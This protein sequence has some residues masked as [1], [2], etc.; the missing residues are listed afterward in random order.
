MLWLGEAIDYIKNLAQ[1]AL[2]PRPIN[3]VGA[4]HTTY[5]AIPSHYDEKGQGS[6]SEISEDP[7]P[8][9]H[10]AFTLGSFAKI[11]QR[12]IEEPKDSSIWVGPDR[13][14]CVIDDNADD[15]TYRENTI[16]L[17][18]T[19]S[20]MFAALHA[21]RGTKFGQKEFLKWLNHDATTSA[22]DPENLDMIIR[23]IKF[24][25]S[26]ETQL[27][28]E[29]NSVDKMGKSV[30]AEASSPHGTI[31]DR[32]R[33]SFNP[34]PALSEDFEGQVTVECSLHVD[35]ANEAIVLRPLPGQMELAQCE[36]MR[37]V[38]EEVEK[39]A[40]GVV[41]FCGSEGTGIYED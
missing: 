10:M 6:V 37:Q 39:V 20:P 11:V 2:D 36:A 28:G 35:L 31:P 19:P 14:Y 33:F 15:S 4:R 34:Y 12:L 17:P 16:T 5:L 32:L 8:R 3:I 18:L 23:N 27:S 38:L 25:Q 1:H 40:N 9:K 7:K 26:T 21:L 30:R 24:A 29:K 41:V 13:I 22:I